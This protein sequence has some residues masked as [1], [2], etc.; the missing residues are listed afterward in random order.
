MGI[1]YIIKQKIKD[2][3]SEQ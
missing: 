2:Y 1:Y 3:L